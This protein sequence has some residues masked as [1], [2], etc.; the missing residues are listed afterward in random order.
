M[1]AQL[2]SSSEYYRNAGGTDEAW[3]TDLY[4]KVLH[5]APDAGGLQ[6]WIGQV[7]SRGRASVASRIYA[8][9]ESRRDRVTALY[10]ALLG[11]GPDPSGLAYWSER[12]ATTGDLE[13]AVRLVDSGEYIR[14]AG[15]RFP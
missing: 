9:P 1:A 3:V 11:R 15:I 2:Y 12:V 4:R 14:R 6:Y 10:E 13:L 5:R 8:S 7:A